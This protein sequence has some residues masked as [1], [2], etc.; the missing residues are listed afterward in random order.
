VK[1]DIEGAEYETVFNMLQKKAL[2]QGTVDEA[3]FESHAW[4]DVTNWQDDRTF[5]ALQ[6]HI[7]AADCGLGGKPTKV[8]DLDDETFKNDDPQA[9][10]KAA[11]AK[12]IQIEVLTAMREKGIMFVIMILASLAAFFM[13]KGYQ[14]YAGES[15]LNKDSFNLGRTKAFEAT[16]DAK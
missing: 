1:V 5:A 11:E 2:C 14:N 10:W 6:K 9:E 16:Q 12:A 3:F 4:G 8:T 13:I 15:L 7:A